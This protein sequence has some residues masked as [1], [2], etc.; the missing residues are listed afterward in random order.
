MEANLSTPITRA[1]TPRKETKVSHLEVETT[2][3]RNGK[4]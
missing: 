2:H 4:A 3:T 1:L